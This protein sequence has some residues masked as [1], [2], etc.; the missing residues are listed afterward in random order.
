MS[1]FEFSVFNILLIMGRFW[2][3]APQIGSFRLL[4]RPATFNLS[5]RRFS[6]KS[7]RNDSIVPLAATVVEPGK[8]YLFN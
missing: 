2:F 5:Q 1:N 6:V 4:D 7:K 3:P 8:F